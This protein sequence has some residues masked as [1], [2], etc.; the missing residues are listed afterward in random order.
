MLA[1]TYGGRTPC[2][3]WRSKCNGMSRGAVVFTIQAVLS[4]AWAEPRVEVALT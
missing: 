3:P 1:C 2:A 4:E